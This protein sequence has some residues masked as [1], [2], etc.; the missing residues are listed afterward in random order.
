M[1]RMVAVFLFVLSVCAVQAQAAGGQLSFYAGYLNPGDISLDNVRQSLRFR[2]TSL[3]GARAEFDFLKVLG[4]EENV[5]FSPR[6]FDSPLF[7]QD[8]SDVRGFLYSTNLVI[9]VPLS[10]FVPYVTGGI[11]FVKPWGTGIRPFDA[12]LAANYGGGIKLNR[13]IGPVGLRFEVRGWRTADIANQ[14]G[15][16]IFEATGAVTFSWK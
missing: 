14:G 1:K 6:L 9:N 5:G 7:P 15:A 16:N 10:R 13:L 12:T 3:F 8:T 4:I 2:G 11:G